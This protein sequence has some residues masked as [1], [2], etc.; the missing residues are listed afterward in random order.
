MAKE[1]SWLVVF[2]AKLLVVA[3]CTWIGVLGKWRYVEGGVSVL[4]MDGTV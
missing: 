2:R 4:V 3:I 1:S